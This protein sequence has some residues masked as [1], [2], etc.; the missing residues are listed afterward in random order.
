MVEVEEFHDKKYAVCKTDKR[1]ETYTIVKDNTGYSSFELKVT[2]G[3]LPEVLKG[4]FSSISKAV[5]AFKQF[6]RESKLSQA[7]KREVLSKER[8]AYRAK[9]QSE[10]S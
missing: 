9:L 10:S 2:K 7:A 8:K 5:E 3:P 1:T 4:K 6:D